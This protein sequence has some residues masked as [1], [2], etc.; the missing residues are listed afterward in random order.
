MSPL[1]LR[2]RR[3]LSLEEKKNNYRISRGGRV[4]ENAFGILTLRWQ[5]LLSTMQQKPNVVQVIVKSTMVLHNLMRSRYPVHHQV[6]M[7]REDDNGQITPRA[8]RQNANMHDMEQVRGLSREATEAKKERE[9]LKLY[10]NSPAG[11]VPWQE[12][13]V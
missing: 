8:W 7:D 3:H 6:L 11:S 5:C 1:G 13:M 10:F 2:T 12:R 9:Y 4:V